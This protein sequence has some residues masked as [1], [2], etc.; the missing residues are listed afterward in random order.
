MFELTVALAGTAKG[1]LLL[2]DP[3]SD[4]PADIRNSAGTFDNSTT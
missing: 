3:G 4:N 2:A 1:I